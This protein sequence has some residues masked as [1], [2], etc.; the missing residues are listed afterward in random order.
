[1]A[2]DC[3]I[4]FYPSKPITLDKGL[5]P[6]PLGVK[7]SVGYCVSMNEQSGQLYYWPKTMIFEIK[8]ITNGVSFEFSGCSAT[9]F[10]IS[11]DGKKI[12]IL[13]SDLFSECHNGYQF[14]GIAFNFTING[15][16]EASKIPSVNGV[17]LNDSYEGR[18]LYVMYLDWNNF[19]IPIRKLYCGIIGRTKT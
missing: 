17:R 5:F 2:V 19:L 3:S 13:T 9:N 15:Q 11:N 4:D 18:W 16:Y 14:D 8:D 12:E 1:M 7:P 6:K 10:E